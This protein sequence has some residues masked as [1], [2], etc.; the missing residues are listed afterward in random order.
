ML[1]E[2]RSDGLAALRSAHLDGIH[3]PAPTVSR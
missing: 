1:G 2:Y 3:R